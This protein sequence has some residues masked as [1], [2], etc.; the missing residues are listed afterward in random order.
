MKFSVLI[1]VY[2]GDDVSQFNQAMESVWCLQDVKPSE[3]VLVIDGCIPTCLSNVIDMWVE[4]LGDSLSLLRLTE[5]VGLGAALNVGLS[6]CRYDL[7]ARM[8]SDDFSLPGRFKS[9]LAYM[10]DNMDVVACSGTVEEWDEGFSKLLGK[11]ILPSGSSE[12]AR[13]ARKRSPLNHPATMFRKAAILD[14]G[15]Y[16]EL[17]KAQ[18][19]ALWSLLITRG[20]RLGNLDIVVL[21]MRTGNELLS[22]RGGT[23]YKEEKKLLD[24][25]YSIGFLTRYQYIYNRAARFLLRNAP[26]S[27]KKVIYRRLR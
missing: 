19:Y 10:N 16:P 4:R 3:I 7:V 1:S 23:Y 14:V 20:Y 5:N 11:R 2:A 9:Q 18:D 24:Y 15:G 6:H 12:L 21:K 27:F 17:R 22:R 13:F 26:N 25:Q 8:D